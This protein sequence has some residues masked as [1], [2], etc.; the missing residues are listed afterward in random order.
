MRKRFM[1][2][3]LA[4]CLIVSLC[5]VGAVTA[6]A[7]YYESSVSINYERARI[8]TSVNVPVSIHGSDN[9]A[10]LK[11]KVDYDYSSLELAD[12]ICNIPGGNFLY[13]GDPSNAQ[14]IWYNTENTSFEQISPLFVLSFNVRDTAEEGTY[15]IA[16][17][18]DEGNVCDENGS[19]IPLH[20]EA[21]ELTV[22]RYLVGDVNGDYLVDS[23]DVVMLARFLVGLETAINAEG[24]DVNRDGNIDGRDLVKLARCMVGM[25]MLQDIPF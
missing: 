25:E 1:S 23:A 15:P 4:V 12:V 11:F 8:G 9:F 19:R 20:A 22:F 18:F 21:G 24:A 14:F 16:L 13:N 5:S 10:C 7:N 6:S 2:M 3:I 17:L